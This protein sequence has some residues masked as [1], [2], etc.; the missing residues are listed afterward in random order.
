MKIKDLDK[1]TL[2][3]YCATHWCNRCPLYNFSEK[4]NINCYDIPHSIGHLK[5]I[6]SLTEISILTKE[7]WLYLRVTIESFKG[8]VKTIRITN[9]CIWIKLKN[10][11]QCKIKKCFKFKGLIKDKDYT[12]KELDL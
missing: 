7:E 9:D 11:S 12:L 4:V 5:K 3:C 10:N 6:D 2:S 1:K 8:V